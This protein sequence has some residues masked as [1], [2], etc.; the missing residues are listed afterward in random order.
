VEL[1]VVVDVRPSD[2]LA[3]DGVLQ[4]PDAT[5][6]LDEVGCDAAGLARR[7]VGVTGAAFVHEHRL[8][9]GPP[10]VD[11]ADEVL[12]GD[13]DVVEELLAELGVTVDLSDLA[14][15]D[16]RC[17]RRDREP[18]EA[19]VLRR[20]PVGPGETH[21][22]VG[23]VGAAG[24]DLRAGD[25]PHVAV[26]DGARADAGEVGARFRLRVELAPDLFPGE[27]LGDVS[28]QELR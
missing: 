12:V 21:R 7:E 2:R 15:R 24:P 16:A 13:D 17:V 11:L 18:R 25:P 9:D 23:V 10:A 1:G 28:L 14:D 5:S 22:P 27:D 4:A 8:G 26:A 6:E 19:A 3:G 20:V